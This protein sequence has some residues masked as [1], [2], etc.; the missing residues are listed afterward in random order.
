[1]SS[2]SIEKADLH[3]R[4]SVADVVSRLWFKW[5][6][7][8]E[9]KKREWLEL[10]NYLFA[11]DTYTTSNQNLPWKNS[12]TYP[13]LTQIRD[14]LHSNYISALFPNEEWLK[15]EAW[16]GQS[17][18]KQ[19]AEAI[20]SY[21]L[22]RTRESDF[23]DTVDRL[24]Y[25][26][27]DYGNAFCTREAVYDVAP[28]P[29]GP[30]EI[31]IGPK[32]KRISPYDIVFDATAESFA[33]SPKIIRKL[34][35]VGD[36]VDAAESNMESNYLKDAFKNREKLRH[37]KKQ[38][39]YEDFAKA[40]GYN[41]DGFGNF[42]E[43]LDSDMVELLE[44]YG[45]LYNRETGEYMKN[46]VITI[47]DRTYVL[48]NEALDNYDGGAPIWMVNWR[49]RPDNLWGA[50]PL[51]GLVGMQYRIDHIQNLKADAMDLAV[52]PPLVIQGE[53]EEFEYGPGA[54]IHCDTEGGVAELNKNL[55]A[56]I[57]AE[58]EADK[59]CL[60]MEEFA[61]AP[62]E[63]MGI[64]T[65]GE[66]TMFEVQ[67]LQNAAGRIFQEKVTRFEIMLEKAL[68][69]MLKVTIQK[70]SSA[71]IVRVVRSDI[72]AEVFRTITA[73]DLNASGVLRPIGARHYARQATMF[74]DLLQVFNSP[75]G[76][77]IMPHVSAK[78]LAELVED[79]LGLKRFSVCT[80]YAAL[81]EQAEM[82]QIQNDMGEQREYEA[83][84]EMDMG[85]VGVG[86]AGGPNTQAAQEGLI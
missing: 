2:V 71:Q 85:M 4:D 63:A 65:P 54:E 64:R 84:T 17:A 9:P 69:S 62:K 56:V 74:Q 44:F 13:K 83:Q 21:M 48:R 80:P 3:F 67:Q 66:K 68:N 20:T 29:S 78:A 36:C 14:N 61:G 37:A 58:S 39:K 72:G 8:R 70:L 28:T 16:D 12:T 77:M 73:D 57:Q 7:Q 75:L 25:D 76:Q 55:N 38:W 50:G 52:L 82:A 45:D 32:L 81:A 60:T 30:M 35:S 41:I 42:F 31:Y 22:D 51:D 18:T 40:D 24:L 23:R 46:R 19:K 47:M 79:Q 1:M 59:L 10:R 26:Y 15:W 53:V 49:M 5:D 11:T 6:S 33:K 43:Y 34:I 86:E 27:I